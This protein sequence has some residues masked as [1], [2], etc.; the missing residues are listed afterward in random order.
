MVNDASPD[1]SWGVIKSIAKKDKRV[2]G[3]DLTRNFGQH[4]A[5]MAG[6]SHV[7]NR[8]MSEFDF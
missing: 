7:F 4:Y 3:I 1:N 2:K 8:S 5:I 6:L